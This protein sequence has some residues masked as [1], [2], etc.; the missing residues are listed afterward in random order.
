MN[1]VNKIDNSTPIVTL[2]VGQLKEVL[3][4]PT[5]NETPEDTPARGKHEYE[6]KGIASIFNC[7]MSTAHRMKRS[8][9]IDGAIKQLGRKI[10][11]DVDLAL[12]LIGKKGEAKVSVKKQIFTEMKKGKTNNPNGRPKGKPNKVTAELKDWINQ[13]ISD[14]KNQ[15]VDDLKKLEP[16]DRLQI[17]ERLMQYVVPKQQSI[18]VEAQIQAEYTELEKLLSNAPEAA[19]DKILERIKN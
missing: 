13:I 9:K 1:I 6:I 15:V 5:C 3:G 7:S 10:I 2:T 12:D 8:G 11:V 14:N 19:I 4:F 18:S 16:K 17:L